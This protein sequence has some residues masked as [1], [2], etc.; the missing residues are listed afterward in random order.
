MFGVNEL[1]IDRHVKDTAAPGNQGGLDV[2]LGLELG[3]QTDRG[4][5]VVS[6]RAVGDRQLHGV[7][8]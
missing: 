1:I 6:S 3:G 7:L 8:L 4:G 2:K 5:F